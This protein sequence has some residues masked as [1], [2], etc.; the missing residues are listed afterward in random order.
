MVKWRDR[1]E[2]AE[3]LYVGEIVELI[4]GKVRVRVLEPHRSFQV[5]K[6]YVELPAN[7]V[8]MGWENTTHTVARCPQCDFVLP[9]RIQ[10]SP[11]TDG[12]E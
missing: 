2:T 1:G 9:A 6:V 12:A 3:F 8:L 4:E 5:G 10:T 7:V 11:K